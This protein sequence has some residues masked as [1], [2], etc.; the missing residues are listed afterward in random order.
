MSNVFRAGSVIYIPGYLNGMKTFQRAILG[1]EL[2]GI[3][4]RVTKKKILGKVFQVD[5]MR[6][7]LMKAR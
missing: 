4:L 2:S 5:E 1:R 3:F 6:I 7:A